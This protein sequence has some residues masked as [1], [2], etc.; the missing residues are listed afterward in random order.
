MVST[1]H[2]MNHFYRY[3]HDAERGKNEYIPTD[4]HWSQVPVG[5]MNG[6]GKLLQTHLNSSS[7]L[8]LS[9]SF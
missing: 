3:W 1:P 8:S 9:V 5:M 7:R 4:V 6:E 2:G